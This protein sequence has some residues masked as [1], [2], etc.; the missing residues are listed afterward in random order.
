ML[1]INQ[2]SKMYKA[3][4]FRDNIKG[5][6]FDYHGNVYKKTL[7]EEILSNE[8]TAKMILKIEEMIDYLI[9]AVKQIPLQYSIAHD[10]DSININ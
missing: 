3:H 5:L 6:G 1:K 2:K 7:S 9:D 4:H 8:R 10:K